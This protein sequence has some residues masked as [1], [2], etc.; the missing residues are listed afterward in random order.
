[1]AESEPGQDSWVGLAEA[2]RRLGRHPDG[3]RAMIRRGKLQA[4]KGNSGQ[5]LV[6]VPAGA[7]SSA[8]SDSDVAEELAALREELT[9]SRVAAARAQAALDSLLAGHERERDSL[10]A[11]V[12]DLR[13]ERDRLAAELAEARRP[14]LLRLLEAL[15]RR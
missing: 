10:N 7:E 13:A 4:C 12:V 5:W 6:Q 8:E 1:M 15:R 9:E 2:A 11:V 14:V 3:L